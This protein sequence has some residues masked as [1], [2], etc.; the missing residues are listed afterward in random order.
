MFSPVFHRE[1]P[2]FYQPSRLAQTIPKYLS[3]LHPFESVCFSPRFADPIVSPERLATEKWSVYP[4]LSLSLSLSSRLFVAINPALLRVHTNGQ[5]T[6][7]RRNR[8]ARCSIRRANG[9]NRERERERRMIKLAHP[10][11]KERSRERV[12][13]GSI[14]LSPRALFFPRLVSEVSTFWSIDRLGWPPRDRAH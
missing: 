12:K 1:D 9:K 7:G 6:T 4:S 5:S 14:F 3:S 2:V 8:M 10:K 13:S 11:E